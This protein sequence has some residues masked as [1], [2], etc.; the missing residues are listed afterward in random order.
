MSLD[1]YETPEHDRAECVECTGTGSVRVIYGDEEMQAPCLSCG[2]TGFQ[3]TRDE[4]ANTPD[5]RL[6]PEPS[7]DERDNYGDE[8]AA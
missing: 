5:L 6:V 7:R 1:L 8:A 2:G 4:L 3:L